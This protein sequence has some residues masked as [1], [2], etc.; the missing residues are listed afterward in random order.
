MGWS[1][2]IYVK[3]CTR[4]Y[5]GKFVQIEDTRVRADK[6]EEEFK[7]HPCPIACTPFNRARRRFGKFQFGRT[8]GVVVTLGSLEMEIG[9]VRWFLPR[10]K[11]RSSWGTFHPVCWYAEGRFPPGHLLILSVYTEHLTGRAQ[12][13]SFSLSVSHRTHAHSAWLK[14]KVYPVYKVRFILAPISISFL[15]VH[16]GRPVRPLPLSAF[17]SNRLVIEPNLANFF[18]HMDTEHTLIDIPDSHRNFLCSDDITVIPASPEGLP[19]SGAS[20]SSKHTSARRVPSM[21]GLSKLQETVAGH[22]SSRPS[23]W[24]QGAVFDESVATMIFSSQSKGERDRDTYVVR[25][26]KD[27]ENLQ[28]ILER[29]VDSAQ[30][31]RERVAQQKL[32]EAE[33]EVEARNWEKRNSDIAFRENNQ[34]F[35]S[36]RFQLHQAS[37]WADQAQRDKISLYGDWW[38]GSSKKIM[39]ALA[40]KLKNWEVFVAKKPIEQDKQELNIVYATT[41]ESYDLESDDG[42]NSGVTD[43]SKF[44]VRCKRILRSWIREQLWSDTRSWSNFYGSEFQDLAAAILDCREI[45]GIIRVLWE[46]SLNDHLFKKDCPLQSSTI[47]RVL[48]LLLRDWDLILPI[49]QGKE[50]MEWKEN[51]W[52]HRFDHCTSKGEV[53]CFPIQVELVLTMVWMVIQELLLQNWILENFLNPWNFKLED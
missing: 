40:M 14:Q 30:F 11:H 15:E 29:K 18:S 17:L 37:R 36:Q 5:L 21:F 41:E 39:Q 22:V 32:Y 25:S 35:E 7:I 12:T 27:W 16:V 9:G 19:H 10:G 43:Q 47:Q 51:R 46:T 4:W 31:E 42:S 3:D 1:F 53:A 28:K 6:A 45:H 24:K 26:L 49:Q 38:I 8:W 44:L 52:I 2:T 48:H 13:H 33:A 23:T 50:R 34:E 20:S